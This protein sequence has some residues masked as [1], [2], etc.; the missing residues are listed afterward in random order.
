M[1]VPLLYRAWSWN[2]SIAAA[3]PARWTIFE[4]E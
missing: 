1:S 4:P 3:L 2:S